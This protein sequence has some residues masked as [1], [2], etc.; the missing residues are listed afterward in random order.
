MKI[1]V[2][3]A[4][5][6]GRAIAS[7][8]AFNH[9]ITAFDLNKE[10]LKLLQ[11][12]NPSINT[13]RVDLSEYKNYKRWF[14]PFDIV[15][16]AVPGFI[17]HKVLK[18][19]I[20]AGKNIVDISFFSE[21]ALALDSLAKEKNVTA[22]VDCGIAPGLSNFILG[23]YNQE[24]K[25]NSF[26]CYVGGLPAERKK[27]FEYKAPFSPKDVIEEYIR[28]ARLN[29]KNKIVTRPAMSEV[30]RMQFDEIG[31]LEA[32]NT[33][34]LRSL[35]FTMPHIPNMKEKTLRYTGHADLI[36]ALKQAGFFETTPVKIGNTEITA[37]EFSSGILMKEW[38][39]EPGEKEFTVLKIVL[40]GEKNARPDAPVGRGKEKKI[41][42]LLL[43]RYD[44]DTNTTSMAR[45]TGYTCTAAVNLLA[46]KMFSEKG[47]FPPEL[48]G[49]NK[50][51]FDFVINYLKERK[52][53]LT[54]E[55]KQ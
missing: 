30:E 38:K 17:G 39:F 5:M 11:N 41:E 8:L 16:S 27:P 47:V 34:G 9:S 7:D 44:S 36:I 19:I 26:E 52:V 43:D 4:G 54:K 3:G 13:K 1:A 55:E 24:M 22:I 46:K 49:K 50:E 42:F 37:L 14:K 6:I 12:K 2:L 31:E 40:T 20:N 18:A 35:L 28:P 32:F 29:E 21:N 33:D 25:I 23:R 15:V 53:V 48:V 45:T 10:N 51:C